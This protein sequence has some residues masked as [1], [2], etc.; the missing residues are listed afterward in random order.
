[1]EITTQ[2]VKRYTKSHFMYNHCT[3][4]IN[5]NAFNYVKKVKTILFWLF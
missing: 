4:G 1:M 2:F 5:P 3:L